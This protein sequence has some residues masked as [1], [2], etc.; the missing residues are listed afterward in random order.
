[1]VAEASANIYPRV[2]PT[3][4][5]DSAAADAIVR[6]AGGMVYQYDSSL[7]PI[8]YIK[9]DKRLKPVIYNKQNLYNPNFVVVGSL[10]C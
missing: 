7:S 6:E 9:K 8:D 1:M 3:K 5:W 2:A 10:E 4:E